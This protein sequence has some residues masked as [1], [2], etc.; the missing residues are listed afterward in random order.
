MF[1]AA[2]LYSGRTSTLGARAQQVKAK[3]GASFDDFAR[4]VTTRANDTGLAQRF[5]WGGPK[6]KFSMV[7]Q[8]HDSLIDVTDRLPSLR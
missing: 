2:L 3:P 8:P 4:E 6:G 1:P 7:V 5:E